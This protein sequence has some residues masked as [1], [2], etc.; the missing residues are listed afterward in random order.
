M[1]WRSM[2]YSALR[3]RWRRAGAAAAA[4][5]VAAAPCAEARQEMPVQPMALGV[6]G[7]GAGWGGEAG[8]AVDDPGVNHESHESRG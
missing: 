6:V 7:G 4:R 5:G 8:V 2:P 1:Q 3:F